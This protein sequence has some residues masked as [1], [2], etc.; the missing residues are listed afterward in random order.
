ML[1]SP[2]SLTSRTLWTSGKVWVISKTCISLC[3]F[4][5][6]LSRTLVRF[7]CEQDWLS[8]VRSTDTRRLDLCYRKSVQKLCQQAP[9]APP[10]RSPQSQHLMLT[11]TE[12]F[13]GHQAVVPTTAVMTG[14]FPRAPARKLPPRI[15]FQFPERTGL[16]ENVCGSSRYQREWSISLAHGLGSVEKLL[17]T[18]ITEICNFHSSF[19]LISLT[20]QCYFQVLFLV[21]FVQGFFYCFPIS[22]SFTHSCQM[23]ASSCALEEFVMCQS[24]VTQNHRWDRCFT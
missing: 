22:L 21:G 24:S 4:L 8:N 23:L 15:V 14:S 17:D 9:D 18:P 2:S 5:S 3:S 1:L 6:S 13:Q 7:I 19:L 20:Y 12:V 11:N 16:G 10:T